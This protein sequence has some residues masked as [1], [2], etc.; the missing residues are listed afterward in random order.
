M[1]F[2]ISG[3]GICL[4]KKCVSDQD[5]DQLSDAPLG[6]IFNRTGVK[7]RYYAENQTTPQMAAHA[8]R[9]AIDEAGWRLSEIDVIISTAAVPHQLIPCTA[10]HIQRELGLGQSGI[11]AFDVNATC[12][13]FLVA[14]DLVSNTLNNGK[15]KKVIIVSSE[16]ASNGIHNPKR[17]ESFGLFGD[18]AV[19]TCIEHG[20]GQSILYSAAF[21]SYGDYADLCQ[22]IGGASR[23]PGYHFIE[24]EKNDYLFQMEGLKLFKQSSL[25]LP[26]FIQKLFARQTDQNA[27]HSIDDLDCVIPHQASAIALDLIRKRLNVPEHKWVSIVANYGNC[28]SASIPLAL[29]IAKKGKQLQRGMQTLLLGTGAGLSL[30]GLLLRY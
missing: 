30:G 13:G 5:L 4:G 29:H 11:Q 28:I 14:C 23:K 22:I 2:K 24:S 10:I 18:A 20:E 21:E 6:T 8:I 19:A 17:L 9:E 7:T 3:T 1:N 16:I 25:L 27:P 12:L 15:W 26:K